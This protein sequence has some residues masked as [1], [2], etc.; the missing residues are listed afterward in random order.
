M[1]YDIIIPEPSMFVSVTCNCVIVI[2]VISYYTLTLNVSASFLSQC[3][4]QFTLGV[5]VC[6]M[7]SEL[8]GLMEQSW[9]QLICC[10]VCL[11][12][13]CDFRE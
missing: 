8:Y 7:G 12:C 11:P 2:Y 1:L 9:L 4:A 10:T 5:K 3:Q 13:G 6:K